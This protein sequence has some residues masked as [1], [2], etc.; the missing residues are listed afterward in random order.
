MSRACAIVG[1]DFTPVEWERYLEDRQYEP[2]CSDL[3]PA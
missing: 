2:T 1:R 3:P